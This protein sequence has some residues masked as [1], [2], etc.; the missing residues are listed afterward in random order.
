MMAMA[1]WFALG[2][3]VG[4]MAPMAWE[5]CGRS[6]TITAKPRR[7]RKRAPVVVPELPPPPVPAD[8]PM[9]PR[10]EPGMQVLLLHDRDG[11]FKH[12]VN[13]HHVQGPLPE[14]Y[15]YGGTDYVMVDMLADGV[16]RYE[17]A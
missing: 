14:T 5:Q 6:F 4:L 16:G 10:A 13:R 8:P 3:L 9:R 11:V 12:E 2:V 1:I 15:E 7:I 17:A